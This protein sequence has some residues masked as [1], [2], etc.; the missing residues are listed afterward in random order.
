[1]SERTFDDFDGVADQ[2]RQ[3]H[4]QN[5][6]ISGADSY[7]FAEM[8][9]R[10][11]QA[12]EKNTSLTILDVGC[13]D[14]STALYMQQYFPQWK[15]VG[16]DV[17]EKSIAVAQSR[18]LPNAQFLTYDGNAIPFKDKQFDLIFIAGVLH[19]IA[20]HLHAALMIEM[21][22]VLKPHGSLYL[23]EH[24]PLNPLTRYLVNTCVFDKDA[25]LL[26]YK[27]TQQLIMAEGFES[28]QLHFII[29][30][31]RKGFF[32]PFLAVEKYLQWLPLGGQYWIKAIK[33]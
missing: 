30:F 31:P 11:L 25:K 12:Y 6:K 15:V 26:P 8:K 18:A 22:R 10:L 21:K 20:F 27:Y 13:G 9:V 19:H 28:I 5:V 7:Y 29:F 23:F 4:T 1:M 16:I 33:P 14:G 24:N 3:I 2:Y 17:S 32:K